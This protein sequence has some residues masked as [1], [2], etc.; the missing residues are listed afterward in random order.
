MPSKRI[1]L[2]KGLTIFE[3]LTVA[4]IISVLAMIAIPNFVRSK[5]D[6]QE[7]SAETNAGV[8]RTMLET[9]KVDHHVYPEDLRILGYEATTKGYNKNATN[10][11]TGTNGSVESGKWAID[12]VGT[13]GP[14]GMTAYQPL[15]DNAKYYI[16]I[17]DRNGQLLKRKGTVYA[18]SNG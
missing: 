2:N 11:F 5:S 13:T 6:A 16:F 7:A 8:L 10:P 9:Y 18:L 14:L 15:A 3:I 12:Y 1:Q 4:I 17:Y